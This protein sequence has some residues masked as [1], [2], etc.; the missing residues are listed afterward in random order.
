MSDKVSQ[1]ILLGVQLEL[2]YEIQ[3]TQSR[4]EE[5]SQAPQKTKNT[6]KLPQHLEKR[7]KVNERLKLH[8]GKSCLPDS[9]HALI[10]YSQLPPQSRRRLVVAKDAT[11][12]A[13]NLKR[14]T[15]TE[16]GARGITNRK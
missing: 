16:R 8:S 1:H 9:S 7:I 12:V 2:L 3:T 14:R 10:R 11:T 4:V 6:I 15:Q 13:A 5:I